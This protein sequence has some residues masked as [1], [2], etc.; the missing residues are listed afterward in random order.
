MT[1]PQ[2]SSFGLQYV[3]V[4]HLAKKQNDRESTHRYHVVFLGNRML[5]YGL[6]NHSKPQRVAIAM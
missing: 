3:S 5:C 2:L 1:L 4:V 6:A